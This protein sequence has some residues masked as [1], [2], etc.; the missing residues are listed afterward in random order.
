MG[1][2]LTEKRQE[3]IYKNAVERLRGLEP[4]SLAEKI[5]PRLKTDAQ[6]RRE[7]ALAKEKRR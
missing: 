6:H 3:E 2:K 1:L 7:E 4:K 5:Y